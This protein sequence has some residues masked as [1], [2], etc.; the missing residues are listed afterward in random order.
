MNAIDLMERRCGI[1]IQGGFHT[2]PTG[3]RFVDHGDRFEI[4][5]SQ[6]L[7]PMVRAGMGAVMQRVG[8]AVQRNPKPVYRTI[9]HKPGP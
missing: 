6:Q 4:G 8:E 2:N 7:S 9:P 5:R 1:A 3:W